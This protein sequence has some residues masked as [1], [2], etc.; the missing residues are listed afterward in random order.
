MSSAYYV[1][2]AELRLIREIAPLVLAA[3]VCGG[4]PDHTHFTDEDTEASRG[5]QNLP[6]VPLLLGDLN[7][8]L[9]LALCLLVQGFLFKPC[10]ET[11][12]WLW[13]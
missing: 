10:A 3:T 8:D 4:H 7:L 11:E 13:E 9:I 12:N 2:D 6:K 5:K 1:L